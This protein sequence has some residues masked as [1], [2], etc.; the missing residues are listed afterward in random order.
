MNV[1]KIPTRLDAESSTSVQE[2][3][4]LLVDKGQDIVLDF[5][6]CV[7]ISSMGLR[8]LLYSFKYSMAKKLSVF[9]VGVDKNV[10]HVMRITGFERY[11]K[12]YD[13]LDECMENQKEQ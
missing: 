2:Q 1:Q 9:L 4:T 8:V 13:T 11:F 12:F 6:S 10:R 3:I 5:S 7:Y